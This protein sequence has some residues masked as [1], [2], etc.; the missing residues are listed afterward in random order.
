MVQPL[1]SEVTTSAKTLSLPL[2]WVDVKIH[3]CGPA[4]PA[5]FL[6]AGVQSEG[7]LSHTEWGGFGG[8]AE[9]EDPDEMKIY[10]E[11]LAFKRLGRAWWMP[12]RG[13]ITGTR[14][15]KPWFSDT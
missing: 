6:L 7:P 10:V 8:V 5:G 4:G 3:R 15:V 14:W 9:A 12:Q 11:T 13:V 1:K 2:D